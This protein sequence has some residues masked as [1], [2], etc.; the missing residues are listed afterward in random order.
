[1]FIF[2]ISYLNNLDYLLILT[3]IK[4]FYF[5]LDYLLILTSIKS[6]SIAL[7]STIIYITYIIILACTIITITGPIILLMPNLDKWL[8]RAVKTIGI[9]AGA[10]TIY[11]HTGGGNGDDDKSRKLQEEYDALKEEHSRKLAE[12][13]A[14]SNLTKE[15]IAEIKK[16]MND[17]LTDKHNAV[18]STSS[19]GASNS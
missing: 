6:F 15:E 4:S 5:N 1:M 3:N 17:L 7:F 2:I 9:G 10:A 12:L 19:T 13:E 11:R 18:A 14:D 8:D 16:Q